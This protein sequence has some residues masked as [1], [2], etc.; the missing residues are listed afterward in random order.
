M[1]NN[2]GSAQSNWIPISKQ[3]PNQR[4]QVWLT[5]QVGENRFVFRGFLEEKKGKKSWQVIN[6]ANAVSSVKVWGY[7]VLAWQPYIT[8]K[9]YE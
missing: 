3:L 8:P 9:P 6:G 7:E 5:V 2:L 4:V 1:M